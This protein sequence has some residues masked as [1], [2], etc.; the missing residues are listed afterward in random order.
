MPP[1]DVTDDAA[2]QRMLDDLAVLLVNGPREGG[3]D[4]E[5]SA[6]LFI[7]KTLGNLGI[8]VKSETVP[9]PEG[10]TSENLWVTFGDGPVQVLI[11]GHYDTVRASP[12][13]DDNGSGIVGLLELARRL[14]RDPIAGVTVTVV[15]FGAEERTF[16]MT[17]ED[18]HYGSR[19][20]G[21]TLAD[22]NELPDWMISLDMVGG[23]HPIA[24]VSLTGTDQSAVDIIVA[25][26][27]AVDME[28]ER[29]ER[30]E[31]SDH[32]TFAKLGVPSVFVWRP[33]NPGYHTEADDTV[34]GPSLVE[35]LK[36]IQAA[37]TMLG[38]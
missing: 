36:L 34:D 30:G 24:G 14:N 8:A 19:L 35:N 20:R 31:I 6:A 37:L 7:R 18:H 28:I 38:M 26:G 2:I 4:A 12:G 13:A 10:A 17:P 3:T 27:V 5:K 9:L 32:A 11:G 25:A 23:T 15:F 22:A 1:L 29:L 16:G 21:A 33:G